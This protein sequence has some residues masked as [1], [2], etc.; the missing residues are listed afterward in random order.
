MSGAPDQEEVRSAVPIPDLAFL[1]DALR[2]G[3][4]A[5]KT[6]VKKVR[7][8]D[9]GRELSRR[10]PEESRALFDAIDDR[11]GAAMLRAAHPVVAAQLLSTADVKRAIHLLEFVPTDNEVAILGQLQPEQRSKIE[12]GY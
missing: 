3:S 8:A 10:T 6:A 5:L 4:D 1:D 2:E 12:Q 11:R 9:L 7:P